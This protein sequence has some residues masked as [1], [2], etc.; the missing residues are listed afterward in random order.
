M[1]KRGPKTKYTPDRVAR[2]LELLAAG[3]T[4]GA[5][6]GAVAID[7]DTLLR[8]TAKYPEFAER[9]RAAESAAEH[10]HVK[11]I[12]DAAQ[13]G[14]VPASIFWLERRRHADWGKK[15]R[16]EVINSV[17][18]LARNANQDEEAAVQAADQILRELRSQ[19]RA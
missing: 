15:D 12:H 10:F 17:R 9:V 11:A 6:C 1:A 7:H 5:T 16:I 19:Q 4:R 13:K 14:S 2:I 18:E 3:N 8:W